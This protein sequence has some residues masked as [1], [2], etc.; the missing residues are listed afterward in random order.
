MKTDYQVGDSVTITKN[1][2]GEDV[3][4]KGW[5]GTIQYNHTHYK[6]Q[7]LVVLIPRNGQTLRWYISYSNVKQT[8]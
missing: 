5:V 2:I 8:K 6:K 1:L 7:Q 4:T 3:P